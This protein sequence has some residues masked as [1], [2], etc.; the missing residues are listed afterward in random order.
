MIGILT[1]LED[2]HAAVR[3]RL[4]NRETRRH[5]AGTSFEVGVLANR[6]D[7]EVVLAAVGPG[8]LNA[9]TLAERL[10]TE[11]HPTAL[12]FVG[13]AGGL[14]EWTRLGDVIV[15]TRVYAYHGGRTENGEF[16][17]RPRAW[18]LAHEL[19]QTT[20]TVVRSSAWSDSLPE[21]GPGSAPA[22]HLGPIAAGDIVHN[23]IDGAAAQLLRTSYN[24]AIAVDMES[25]GLAVAAQLNG[26]VPTVSIRAV[27]DRADGAKAEAHREG[28]H[29]VAAR[30]AA[31]F[32]VALAAAIDDD[33]EPRGAR[34]SGATPAMP[35]VRNRN[36]AR[37]NA[38][39]GQQIGVNLGDYHAGHEPRGGDR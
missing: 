5:A 12:M 20:R 28:W 33:G 2:E 10:I 13:V 38:R 8:N 22:V 18:D 35:A 19:E 21:A 26:A 16:L 15:A 25:A 14:R 32:A 4:T 9:A 3:A 39:V 37:D 34:R 6:P 24:D 17:A 7:R 29:P 27:S 1:A 36:V 23:S 31:A 11:F 30:N